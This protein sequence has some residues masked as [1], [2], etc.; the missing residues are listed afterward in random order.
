MDYQRNLPTPNITTNDV[1]YRR[2]LN[3]I[4]FNVHVLSDESSIF[5]TYDKTVARK[6]A[7]DVCSMLEHYFFKILDP[8]VRQ[9]IIFCDSC[10]GQNK[11]YTTMRFFHYMVCIKNVSI[12]LKWCSQF[13]VA[14]I[15]NAIETWEK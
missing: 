6:G 4:S 13:V 10:A 15:W 7:D 8:K 5:Y 2:Q 1:Y 3:F 14:R 9:L 12:A 11:K